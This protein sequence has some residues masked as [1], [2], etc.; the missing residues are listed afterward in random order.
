MGRSRV[1]C[2]PPANANW[3]HNT[4]APQSIPLT[5]PSGASRRDARPGTFGRPSR[6][7]DASAPGGHREA[8]YQPR[9]LV[10]NK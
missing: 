10:R 7:R 6:I 4:A 9:N 8:L 5:H 1:Y 2:T 3:Q